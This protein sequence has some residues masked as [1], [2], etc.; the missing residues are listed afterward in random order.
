[1]LFCA[2]ILEWLF[3]R[4]QWKFK[5]WIFYTGMPYWRRKLTDLKCSLSHISSIRSHFIVAASFCGY[6]NID[7]ASQIQILLTWIHIFFCRKNDDRAYD[8]IWWREQ[9]DQII[10]WQSWILKQDLPIMILQTSLISRHWKW[11]TME[12][13]SLQASRFGSIQCAIDAWKDA[14]REDQSKFPTSHRAIKPC[15]LCRY[16]QT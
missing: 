4:I 13:L 10:I 16:S 9:S 6:P 3:F 15:S 5:I 8:S 12:S 1:M 11:F 14:G 7:E 2:N